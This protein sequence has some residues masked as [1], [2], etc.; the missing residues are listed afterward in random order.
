MTYWI[1][2]ALVH[3]MLVPMGGYTSWGDCQAAKEA[4]ERAQGET[5]PEMV[6]VR[7]TGVGETK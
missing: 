5:A 3:A 1:L 6:C 4:V 2:V 7:Q